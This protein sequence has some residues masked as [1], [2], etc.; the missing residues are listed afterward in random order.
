MGFVGLLDATNNK[1]SLHNYLFIINSLYPILG[2]DDEIG[3]F[4]VV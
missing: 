3:D 1:F 2:H 4:L